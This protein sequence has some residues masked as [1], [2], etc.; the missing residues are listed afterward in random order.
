MTAQQA[1]ESALVDADA[2]HNTR[3][4][5]AVKLW[6]DTETY[7]ATPIKAGTYRYVADSELL[8]LSWAVDDGPVQVWDFTADDTAPIDL[9][10]ALHNCAQIVA[11]NAQFDRLV[12]ERHLGAHAPRLAR[13]RC[14]MVQAYAHSLPG[15]LAQ[16]GVA[17]GLPSNL[18]KHDT[19]K[20]LTGLFC[21]P[22]PKTLKLRRATRQT[23][24]EH[25]AQ[26][27]AYARADVEAMR[28]C[29]KRMPPWNYPD[30]AAEVA[31]WH[32]DQRINDRGF[33][34]DVELAEAAIRATSSEQQRLTEQSAQMTSGAVTRAT[35]RDALLNFLAAE[36]A[37]VLE[38]LKASTIDRVLSGDVDPVVRALLEVRQQA[39]T[40]S[41]SKYQALVNGHTGGRLRGTMQFRG[42]SRTGRWAGRTF[43]PQNLPSRDLLPQADI[44]MGIAALKA[45]VAEMVFPNI[46]Q[47]T[48]SCIR[49]AIT[50]AAGHKLVVADLAN[51]EGRGLAWLAGE[52]WKL[53]AFR[54]FDEGTGPDLYKLTYAK[55]F[56]IPHQSV[57]KAQRQIGKVMELALG[58]E[59]GVG[60]FVTFAVAYGI[61]LEE[62]ARTAW[63][64][65]PPA[66]VAEAAEFYQWQVAEG[67]STHGLTREAFITCDV[68]KRGWRQGHPATVK[69]WRGLQQS[70][71]NA[72]DS[73]GREYR[74]GPLTVR[75]DQAWLRIILPSGRALCYP[76]PRIDDGKI[77]YM[78]VDQFTRKWQRLSTY[79]GKL[80]ENVTQGFSTDVLSHGI[81]LAEAAG[82]EVGLSVHDELLTEMRDTG[83]SYL[84]GLKHC[85]T[86]TPDWA[87]GLPL[88][89]AGFEGYRYRKD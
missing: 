87:P 79:S 7:S 32:L 21:K 38:D 88:A 65:L 83:G 85:M 22:M 20:K 86:T 54:A 13:W 10:E 72:I 29:A 61:D 18:A 89:A 44:D 82:F 37:L 12:L 64:S 19:G 77:T 14:T 71:L 40:T 35:Q 57:T 56:G 30:R 67:R 80:V 8:L 59:G 52:G 53:Q 39:S 62:L 76:G 3:K 2:R 43:Q 47:L 69:L 41:T 17:L 74:A 31:L 58:Y 25:W 75:R 68:F 45:N 23:H 63:E 50:S 15:S 33:E 48:S 27:I 5:Q 49:S 28:E 42:A 84:D 66:L 73:P 81:E 11:H 78:G 9:L 26:F 51:I 46:M 6:V 55:A 4:G 60:A 36:H 16:L 24:P 1:L 70:V 34:V